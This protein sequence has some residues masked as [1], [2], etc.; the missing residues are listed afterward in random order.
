MIQLNF[1]ILSDFVAGTTF[2]VAACVCFTQG[3]R[4][5]N[6]ALVMLGVISIAFGTSVLLQSLSYMILLDFFDVALQTK[7]VSVILSVLGCVSV[8]VFVNHV[9]FE[10]IRM[11]LLIP[12]IILATLEIAAIYF[13]NSLVIYNFLEG[14]SIIASSLGKAGVLL[15]LDMVLSNVALN[16]VILAYWTKSYLR[17]PGP[18]KQPALFLVMFTWAAVFAGIAITLIVRFSPNGLVNLA[19]YGINYLLMTAVYILII[20]LAIRHPQL[21]C[22]LP[23]RV[24]R[25]LVIHNNSGLPL[26]DFQFSKQKVDDIL[27]SGLIQGLQQMSIEVLQK[28]Q[29]HQIILDSGVLTFKKSELYTVGLL[30]SRSSQILG[31]SFNSFNHAFEKQFSTELQQFKGERSVFE[32]ATTLVHTYFDFVPR[33]IS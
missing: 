1:E 14:G 21:L 10:R 19:L 16:L 11:V 2:L 17:A 22:I 18:L 3:S 23:F 5:H 33:E 12:V 26:F 32:R 13:T 6:N 31:R 25:L 27:F 24:D 4:K 7:Q 15:I 8:F 20:T 30:A 29:I 28:G 9:W